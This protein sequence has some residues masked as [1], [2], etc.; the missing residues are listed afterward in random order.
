MSLFDIFSGL[1]S[2]AKQKIKHVQDSFK[3]SNDSSEF[4]TQYF[5]C[6]SS[7]YCSKQQYMGYTRSYTHY[8]ESMRRNKV[9]QMSVNIKQLLLRVEL[10]TNTNEHIP[11][12]R[13]TKERRSRT[14]EFFSFSSKLYLYRII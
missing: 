10:L 1:F 5:S 8:F 14:I 9:H 6:S 7:D 2:L 4:Y 12:P 3:N 11:P 13:N